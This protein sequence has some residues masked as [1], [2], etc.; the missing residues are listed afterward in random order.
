M[1][2][3]MWDKLF[4]RSSGQKFICCCAVGGL[5]EVVLSSLLFFSPTNFTNPVKK[6]NPIHFRANILE[7]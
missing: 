7:T 4:G 2:S 3:G 6:P 1:A 5:Q